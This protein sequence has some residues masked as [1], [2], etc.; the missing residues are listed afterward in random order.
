MT[1]D[2]KVIFAAVL[3]DFDWEPMTLDNDE[4]EYEL[5]PS[6]LMQGLRDAIAERDEALVGT[7]PP[8]VDEYRRNDLAG[9]A[10][11]GLIASPRDVDGATQLR[12]KPIA[13]AAVAF[14]DA[15]LAELAKGPPP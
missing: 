15:L 1:L 3:L 6:A 8:E 10:M 11:Q 5:V 7:A 2:D 12:P 4:T 9:M 14:A 13:A